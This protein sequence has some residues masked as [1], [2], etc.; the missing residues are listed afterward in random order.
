MSGRR[1]NDRQVR[2]YMALRKNGGTQ[3]GSAAKAGFSERTARRIEKDPVLPSQKRLPR[4]YRTRRD[5]FATAWE[6]DLLPLLR[7]IPDIRATTLLEELQRL[8][9]DRYSDRQL[10]SLQR[11]VAHWRA[12][13]GPERDLIFRQEHPP[14]RQGLSDFTDASSL[15]VTIAGAPFRHR[16]YHF[17]LAYSGWEYAKAIRG[18][19]SFT[20]LAEG[21][22]EALWQLGG[23]PKE[24]RTDR[25][26]AA[27]RNLRAEDDAA[28]AYADLLAHYGA[29]PSRN[30]PG[31]SHENGAIE[32]AHGHLKRSLKEALLLRG[33]TDFP[34]LAAYQAFL[35]EAVARKNARRR[36]AV[37]IELPA[38]LTLPQRRTTD[39]STETVSVTTSGTMRVRG[40][41]Y[42]VPSRLV[43][44]RLRVHVYDDR[45]ACFLGPTEVLRLP[46]AARLGKNRR[47]R[48]VDYRHLIGPLV[49]KPQAFR[50]SV[51][52][53]DLF[54]RPAFRR[55]WEALD[56]QLE[57]RRACR[58]YV[59]LL[60]LAALHNCEAALAERLEAI[61]E[62]GRLPDLEQLRQALI[63][64]Q[65]VL[66]VV[67][68]RAP[69]PAAYDA[70]L[71]NALPESAP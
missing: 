12:T 64:A 32:A 18:G 41:L 55:A 31:A 8:H 34:D 51:F 27:Y 11:R 30:N 19:E 57:P 21:L 22:Q 17:W 40:A 54:P 5:P 48:Q 14:G 66:P 39:F 45:L 50:H 26:S 24:H 63:P 1:V 65:P 42:T 3:A 13:E 47:A 25:L 37:A 2:L 29:R 16:L 38:L 6:Q 36:A 23:A 70:L 69:D 33:S 62:A 59:G 7:R 61:L 9:P 10:R 44:C 20:A 56:A 43:G 15:G 60:H 71:S 28:R 46:R 53:E 68:V 52:R 49:R 58:V 67:T 35:Q 4:R